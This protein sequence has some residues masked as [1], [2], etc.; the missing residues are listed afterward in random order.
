MRRG[1]Y[2]TSALAGSASAARRASW[3]A[4]SRVHC[5]DAPSYG[6]SPKIGDS[7]SQGIAS[8]SAGAAGSWTTGTPFRHVIANDAISQSEIGT[9]EYASTTNVLPITFVL[10]I[11]AQNGAILDG[12]AGDRYR[13][14]GDQKHAV[15]R[16]TG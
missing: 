14:I 2:G 7:S 4:D 10:P 12:H 9:V 13:R 16:I 15:L 5:H 6:Q 8:I 1:P 11:L 3:A